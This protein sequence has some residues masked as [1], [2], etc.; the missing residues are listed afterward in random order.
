M[1][2]DCCENCEF[3]EAIFQIGLPHDDHICH[4][5][6]FPKQPQRIVINPEWTVDDDCPIEED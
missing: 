3:Y 6:E 4:H 5:P 1:K 2:P